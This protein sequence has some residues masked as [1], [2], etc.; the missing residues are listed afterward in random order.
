[1]GA[2]SGHKP[3]IVVD[4][5]FEGR[6]FEGVKESGVYEEEKKRDEAYRGTTEN[7]SPTLTLAFSQRERVGVK[8]NRTG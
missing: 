4:A 5:S 1:L 8:E 2:R 7:R 6:D 3:G